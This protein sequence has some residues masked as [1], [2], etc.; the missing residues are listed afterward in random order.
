LGLEFL[1]SNNATEMAEIL[2]NIQNKFV[3]TAE[4]NN[5]K[6]VLQKTFLDGDQLTEERA[7]NAQLANSL[8][9]TEYERLAGF[10]TAFADWH[11]G[12]NLLMVR[13]LF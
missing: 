10:E 8:A 11:L 13:M 6:Y 3:P 7:R 12:K 9:Q 4:V 5:Q 2:N 1:N